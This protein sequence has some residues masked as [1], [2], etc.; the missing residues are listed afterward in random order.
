MQE[1]ITYRLTSAVQETKLLPNMRP[2]DRPYVTL[3]NPS[4]P[5]R[6]VMRHSLLASVLDIVAANSRFQERIAL[7]E[8]GSVFLVSEEQELP[9]EP[10]RLALA[11]TGQRARESWANGQSGASPHYDFFDL[12]GILESLFAALHLEIGYEP[13]RHPT[14]RPGRTAR[15][16]LGEQQVGMMGEL[17]PQVVKAFEIRAE[18]EQ[19]VLA[20]ELDLETI[21]KHVPATYDYEPLSPFPPVREDLALV[22]NVA[23][24]AAEVEAALRQAGG[25]LLKDVILFDVYQGD[26]LPEGK[27]SLAYHLVFQAPDKTLNDKEVSRQRQRILRLL[28]QQLGA[29]L[30]A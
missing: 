23:T 26:R 6:Q 14:Y 3:A 10:L 1:V 7:Y 22:V 5:E 11:L 27:K 25:R 19:P 30:R 4:S 13:A 2:D 28:E 18:R 12:K 29:R 21:L 17:Y 15:L 20:A 8:I 9:D 24:P 16:L